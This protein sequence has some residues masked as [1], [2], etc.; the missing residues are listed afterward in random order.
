MLSRVN[1]S[2]YY[3]EEIQIKILMLCSQQET[4]KLVDRFHFKPFITKHPNTTH[5]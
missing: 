5:T 2:L 4:I 1:N 3:C